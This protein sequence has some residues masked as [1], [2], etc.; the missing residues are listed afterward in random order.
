MSLNG[1]GGFGGQAGG[2][3]T[4]I[5]LRGKQLVGPDAPSVARAGA[6]RQICSLHYMPGEGAK[7]QDLLMQ[8]LNLVWKALCAQLGMVMERVPMVFGPDGG[9]DGCRN[10]AG[11]GRVF[12]R[13]ESKR[14]ATIMR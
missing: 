2:I 6:G 8:L 9:R 11:A 3:C 5:L 10:L 7:R 1:R 14:K 4:F 12:I 13:G